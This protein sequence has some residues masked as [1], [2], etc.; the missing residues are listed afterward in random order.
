MIE[1]TPAFIGSGMLV[2]LNPAFSFFGG[3]FLAWGV[4]GPILVAT[5]TCFGLPLAEEDPKWGSYMSYAHF[6][7]IAT[8]PSPRYWLLWP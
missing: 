3:T 5:G 1:W 4:I 2:G 8:A 6:S 7:N